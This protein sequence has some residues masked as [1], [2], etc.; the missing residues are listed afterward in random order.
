VDDA[1][2]AAGI[3]RLEQAPHF[4]SAF[5]EDDGALHAHRHYWARRAYRGRATS[6]RRCL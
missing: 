6:F 5:R 4:A 2:A 1:P 3:R